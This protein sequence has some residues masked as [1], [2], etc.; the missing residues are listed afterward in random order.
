MAA[1]SKGHKMIAIERHDMLGGKRPGLYVGEGLQ[2]LKVG[3][4]AS[5]E[6]ADLFEKQ[7]EYFFGSLLVKDEEVKQ[8]AVY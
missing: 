3:T 6:K 4:F 1:Y 8:D 2:I 5:E 7:L